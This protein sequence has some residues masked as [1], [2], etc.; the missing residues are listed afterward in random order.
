[1]CGQ[2]DMFP[3]KASQFLNKSTILILGK[4]AN[5]QNSLT[6]MWGIIET[7]ISVLETNVRPTGKTPL[8]LC[9]FL[10]ILIIVVYSGHVSSS[11][12]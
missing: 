9:T 11:L 12:D 4:E 3:G 8:M 2:R 10:C 5:L 7:R 1:M 6:Q